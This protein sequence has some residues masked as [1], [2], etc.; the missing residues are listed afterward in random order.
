MIFYILADITI[1][2]PDKY[3][4]RFVEDVWYDWWEREVFFTPV[5]LAK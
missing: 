2:L 5:N 1:P 4:P 3:S